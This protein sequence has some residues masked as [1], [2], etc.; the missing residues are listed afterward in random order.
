MEL[1]T[2]ADAR[3]EGPLCVGEIFTGRHAIYA[4]DVKRGVVARGSK[5]FCQR[6][7]HRSL[8][9]LSRGMENP[10]ALLLDEPVHLG[11]TPQ[12]RQQVMS[13]RIARTNGVETASHSGTLAG[14]RTCGPVRPKQFAGRMAQLPTRAHR[15]GLNLSSEPHSDSREMNATKQGRGTKWRHRLRRTPESC[16]TQ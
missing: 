11:Q 13:G 8:A 9:H 14:A 5:I 6:P 10:E 1:G 12:Y 3:E 7:Q 15:M 4:G 16:S 2:V